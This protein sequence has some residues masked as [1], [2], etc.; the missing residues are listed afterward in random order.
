MTMLRLR[1][2][3][4]NMDQ[5]LYVAYVE[6]ASI[7]TNKGGHYLANGPLCN[8]CVNGS[9]LVMHMENKTTIEL[10]FEEAERMWNMVQNL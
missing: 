10:F 6:D 2:K 9:Y 7:G 8:I 3:V 4:F 5:V 1:N